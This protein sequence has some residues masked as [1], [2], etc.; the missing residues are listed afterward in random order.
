[1]S[2]TDKRIKKTEGNCWK[3]F[4]D[5]ESPANI[6]RDCRAGRGIRGVARRRGRESLPPRPSRVCSRGDDLLPE[7]VQEGESVVR[8]SGERVVAESPATRDRHG[9][10]V[11]LATSLKGTVLP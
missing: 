11:R 10:V 4:I 1:M 5:F 3:A 8:P 2:E 6:S 7:V 9:E